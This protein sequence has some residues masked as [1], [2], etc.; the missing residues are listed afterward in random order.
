MHQNLYTQLFL[1]FNNYE[2]PNTF[3]IYSLIFL[4]VLQLR[5]AGATF[6]LRCA[7]FSL[8]FFLFRSKGSRAHWLQQLWLLGS[9]A[10]AQWL[11]HTGLVAPWH[12]EYSWI[13][14]RT[15]ISCI[16]RWIPHHWATREAPH[17]HILKMILTSMRWV[18]Q[19]VS[20]GA[21]VQFRPIY[22][23]FFTIQHCLLLSLPVLL[24]YSL[25]RIASIYARIKDK[26]KLRVTRGEKKSCWKLE[27][28]EEE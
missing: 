3:F 15:C 22:L 5:Q 28:G 13:G 12:V 19:R 18:I 17:Q 14:D 16:G 25:K 6:Q 1:Y 2:R 11:W 26:N 7:G 27:E 9:R 24:I 4:A 8:R 10:Q 21:G 23:A 20:G